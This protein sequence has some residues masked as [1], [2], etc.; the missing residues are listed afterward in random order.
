MM[1]ALGPG[2]SRP[3]G[4]PAPTTPRGQASKEINTIIESI[5]QEF[6]LPLQPRHG[7]F[8][9]SKR[10]DNYAE[11]C[12]HHI[13]FLFFRNRIVMNDVFNDF[14]KDRADDCIPGDQLEAFYTRI[15]DAVYLESNKPQLTKLQLNQS[16]A[17]QDHR[18]KKPAPKLALTQTKLIPTIKKNSNSSHVK[19]IDTENES[20]KDKLLPA[21]QPF[22]SEWEPTSR[23][24]KRLP[25]QDSCMSSK[26]VRPLKQR[27]QQ[28]S[29]DDHSSCKISPS[30]PSFASSKQTHS[31][32]VY[33]GNANHS[34]ATTVATSFNSG[35]DEWDSSS[36]DYGDDLNPSQA[37]K[38][39]QIMTSFE[40]PSCAL[41][42]SGVVNGSFSK[43]G[44]SS[45]G[46]SCQ[47]QSVKSETSTAAT[48]VRFL[49]KHAAVSKVPSLKT[50]NNSTAKVL[51]HRLVRTLPTDGLFGSPVAVNV[52]HSSFHHLYESYRLAEATGRPLKYYA[53]EDELYQSLTA[54]TQFQRTPAS[55]WDA[56]ADPTQ[57]AN[58]MLKANLNFNPSASTDKLLTLSL[59]LLE[60][61]SACILQRRF[62]SSRFLYVELPRIHTFNGIH[63]KGQQDLLKSRF[64]E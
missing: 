60:F 54:G 4:P 3:N 48:S 37:A 33:P 24:T 35:Y 32:S 57:S 19:I 12:V 34:F 27:R 31:T 28:P 36:A 45:D 51:E 23:G 20:P 10:P 40:Q 14:R 22:V 1:A 49:G 21:N 62:G 41:E 50:K 55:V 30:N 11:R 17:Q 46:Q 52:N 26:Y 38:I 64:K 44:C 29:L 8:S 16:G 63:L 53:N 39:E 15:R 9:A 18:C 42:D 25:D 61:E 58:V 43:R 6:S 5:A 2:F 13:N 56:T 7:T 47:N 59:Q